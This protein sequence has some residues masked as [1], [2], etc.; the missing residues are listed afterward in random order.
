VPDVVTLAYR[1]DAY[2]YGARQRRALYEPIGGF[3]VGCSI[4]GVMAL[5]TA[6]FFERGRVETTIN[7]ARYEIALYRSP[8]GRGLRAFFPRFLGLA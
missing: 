7:G 4:E 2:D 5:G 3:W 6:R 8:D 1:W